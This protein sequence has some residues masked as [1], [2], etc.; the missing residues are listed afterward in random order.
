MSISSINVEEVADIYY[1]T[2]I[3]Y[4]LVA[5]DRILFAFFKQQFSF[6]K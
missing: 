2:V 4:F 5:Y 6:K 3:E 1:G